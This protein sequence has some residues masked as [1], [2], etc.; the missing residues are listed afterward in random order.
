M[1]IKITLFLLIL[2]VTS[3]HLFSQVKTP[4]DTTQN[5]TS[6]VKKLI[7]TI[8]TD[9]TQRKESKRD[10]IIEKKLVKGFYSPR[11][12]IHETFLY[13]ETPIHW[14]TTDWIRV[15]ITLATVA[16]ISPFDQRMEGNKWLRLTSFT[17]E[18]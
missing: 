14:R 2:F 17:L 4:S 5:D 15:G 6:K 8:L 3:T 16:A 11:Q 10:T 7:K 9:T 12:F 13:V 1:R 18:R